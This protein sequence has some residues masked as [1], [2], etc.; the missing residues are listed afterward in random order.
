[1]PCGLHRDYDGVVVLPSVVAFLPPSVDE[2]QRVVDRDAEPD[3]GDQELDDERDVHDVGQR[4]QQQERRE[5][6]YRRDD[7]RKEREERREHERQHGQRSDG[8]EHG[9][10]EDARPAVVVA[11]DGER[12]LAGDTGCGAGRHRLLER[13]ADSGGLQLGCGRRVEPVEDIRVRGAIVLRTECLV[14]GVRLVDDT[15]VGHRRRHRGETL[16]DVGLVAGDG[17]PRR[18]GNRGDVRR[19]VTAA[20]ERLLDLVRGLGTGLAR[21]REVDRQPAGRLAG[22]SYARN[23]DDT[24]NDDYCLAMMQDELGPPAHSAPNPSS[25]PHV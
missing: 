16:A 25:Q 1:M 23:E 20:A 21:Q 5:D 24:P 13:A 22:Q 10:A 4:Q 6:R 17:L 15:H 2:Q 19:C 11:A 3:Q 14:A 18:H 7:Q 8:A 12:L 9:L